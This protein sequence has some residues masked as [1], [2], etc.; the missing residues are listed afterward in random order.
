M[1]NVPPGAS[2]EAAANEAAYRILAYLYPAAS[3][4]TLASQFAAVY[5]SAMSAIPNGQAKTDGIAVGVAAAN[6]LG[7]LRQVVIED[8]REIVHGSLSLCGVRATNAARPR[9]MGHTGSRPVG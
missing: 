9:L 1:A 8:A 6:G 4:S 5:T 7:P 2:R 3:F